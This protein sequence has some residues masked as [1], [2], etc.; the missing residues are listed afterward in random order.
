MVVRYAADVA[1]RAGAVSR[2]LRA[3]P[4][5]GQRITGLTRTCC[6]RRRPRARRSD[7][8]HTNLGDVAHPDAW[9]DEELV[10]GR[11]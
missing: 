4:R 5:P 11:P 2:Y 6:P 7:G 8:D 1:T 10:A 9:R 3:A